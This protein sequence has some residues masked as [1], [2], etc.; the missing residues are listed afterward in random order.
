MPASLSPNIVGIVAT[1]GDIANG[2]VCTL[3][4]VSAHPI[5][6]STPAEVTTTV[7]PLLPVIL[8]D[9]EVH[10]EGPEQPGSAVVHAV[11]PDV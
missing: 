5:A 8:V 2:I 7:D 10:A 9:T 3:L 11:V 4:C 6:L 1:I